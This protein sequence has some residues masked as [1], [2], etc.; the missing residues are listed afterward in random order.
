MTELMTRPVYEAEPYNPSS[1]DGEIVQGE[2]IESSVEDNSVDSSWQRPDGTPLVHRP[3]VDYSPAEPSGLDALDEIL[4]EQS[5]ET[6]EATQPSLITAT[7]RV[8]RFLQRTADRL[9][10]GADRAD[11]LSESAEKAKEKVMGFGRSALSRLKSAGLITLGLGVMGAKA[12]GRGMKNVGEAAKTSTVKL[13][14]KTGDAFI[15]GMK[16]VESGMDAAGTQIE[17]FKQR[18]EVNKAH[19]EAIQE[20]RERT[21]DAQEDA[22]ASYEDNIQRS[23]EIDEAYEEHEAFVAEQD[24]QQAIINKK[25]EK[26]LRM[27]EK[28]DRARKRKADAEKR[29]ADRRAKWAKRG[30][31][32][33]D[34][35]KSVGNTIRTNAELAGVV[36]REQRVK[37]GR[38]AAKARA[39]GEGAVEGWKSV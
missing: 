38:V 28:F 1:D 36:A 32:F 12:T 11:S 34:G 8:G 5:S 39:A 23:A 15:A 26:A 22:F 20:D 33:V 35:A 10:N 9:E 37:L 25:H 24:R 2:V 18:R 21:I 16:K 13:G 31:A 3:G 14:E 7:S 6:A 29:K 27:N 4:D 17:A 19:K 30:K